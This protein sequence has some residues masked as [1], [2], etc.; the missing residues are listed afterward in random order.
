MSTVSTTPPPAYPFAAIVG[1]QQMREALCLLAIDPRIGGVVIRGA[2]GSAKTT[3][4]RGNGSLL[5]EAEH[6]I[7]ELPLGATEDR[8]VGSFDLA[9]VLDPL[10]TTFNP[11]F[12]PKQMAVSSTLMRLIC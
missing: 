2:K 5:G 10:T 1:Q 9:A 6:P 11:G 12:S 7:V 3:A 8:V 4:V